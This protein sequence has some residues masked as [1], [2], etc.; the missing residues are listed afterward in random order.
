MKKTKSKISRKLNN[1]LQREHLP[2]RE[3]HKSLMHRTQSMSKMTY[4]K[5]KKKMEISKM[6]IN[7]TSS[8]KRKEN[9]NKLFK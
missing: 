8:K 5:R 6:A 4:R 9:S 7:S 2:G 1:S 3:S